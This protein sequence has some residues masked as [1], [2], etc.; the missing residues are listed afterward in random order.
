MALSN[1]DTLAVDLEGK[2]IP[3]S[4]TSPLGVQVCFHKNWLYVFDEKAWRESR[5]TRPIVMQVEEGHITYLDTHIQAKR[6]PQEGI[7]AIITSGSEWNKD[8]KGMVG[9]GVYGFNDSTWVGVNSESLTFLKGLL[10]SEDQCQAIQ[11]VTLDYALRV[12]QG[13]LYFAANVGA[14][15]QATK[16]G[17]SKEPHILKIID[18][19][20]GQ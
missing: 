16:P 3:G 6:G 7:F 18:E 1:W 15:P 20:K 17:E 9:C 8:L 2:P 19:M 13:D 5:Y 4:F 11:K 10:T 12:N 14:D